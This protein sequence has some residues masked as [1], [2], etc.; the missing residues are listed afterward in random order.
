MNSPFRY[1]ALPALAL[2]LAFIVAPMAF[3]AGPSCD[4][5]SCQMAATTECDPANCDPAD[6]MPCDL[7]PD[8]CKDACTAGSSTSVQCAVIKTNAVVKASEV[9]NCGAQSAGCRKA[10]AQVD[11]VTPKTAK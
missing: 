2:A 11:V 4:I 3:A 10:M 9:K 7:C 1:F 8:D 5:K 6:C